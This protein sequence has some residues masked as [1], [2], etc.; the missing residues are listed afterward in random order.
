MDPTSAVGVAAAFVQFAEL[1]VKG[2]LRTIG[3][4]QDLEERPHRL[5]ELLPNIDKS[6]ARIAHLQHALQS[7]DPSPI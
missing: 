4:L 7:T 6:V 1:T 3:F 5:K 2:V